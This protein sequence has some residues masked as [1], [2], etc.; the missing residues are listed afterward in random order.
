M[1]VSLRFVV[2]VFLCVC[3]TNSLFTELILDFQ[4]AVLRTF[5]P[6]C[7]WRRQILEQDVQDC[8]QRR[9]CVRGCVFRQ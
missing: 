8:R 7:L 6:V 2:G 4:S 1:F 9:P 5:V 3:R